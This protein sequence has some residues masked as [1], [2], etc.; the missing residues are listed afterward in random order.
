MTKLMAFLSG[1]TILYVLYLAIFFIVQRHLMYPGPRMQLITE[2]PSVPELTRKTVHTSAGDEEVLYLPPLVSTP[3]STVSAVIFAHGNGEVMDERVTALDGFRTLGMALLLVE[4][5]GYGRSQGAP[6]EKTIQETMLA[7]YDF[8]V[9][10]PI[11]DPHRVV[12]YG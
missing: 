4:Y 11:I 5:P 7:A 6:S 3:T 2:I 8:L 12:A 1:A 10:V 9:S